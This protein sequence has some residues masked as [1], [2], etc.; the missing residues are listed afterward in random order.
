M[1]L[2]EFISVDCPEPL[3]MNGLAGG[4]RAGHEG[5]GSE[6]PAETRRPKLTARAWASPS[7]HGEGFKPGSGTVTR[8]DSYR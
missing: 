8:G 1:E 7:S 5:M 4:A 3:G 6:W 2:E